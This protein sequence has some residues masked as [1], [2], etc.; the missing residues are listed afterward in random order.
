MDWVKNNRNLMILE[1]VLFTILGF[2]AVAMPGIS[3][4]SF[5]LFSGWLL[6]FGGIFQIY[7]SFKGWNHSPAVMGSLLTGILYFIFGVL[8]ILFPVAGVISLTA[9]LII[10]FIAEGIAKFILGFQLRPTPQW[11]LFLLNGALALIMAYIIWRG[12][13][14]TAYWVLGLLIGINM[15]FF[16]ISLIFLGLSIPKK[17]VK[18]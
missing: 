2:I 13:P 14:G 12:F 6:I 4:L 17:D 7:R 18:P 5:E 9:L 1:G 3:T 8:L 16:G 10:F 15:I 11:S